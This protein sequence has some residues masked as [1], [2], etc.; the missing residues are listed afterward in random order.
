MKRALLWLA[1]AF[2]VGSLLLAGT[3]A[4]GKYSNGFTIDPTI[5]GDW[6]TVI[7]PNPD[8]PPATVTCGPFP[9]KKRKDNGNVLSA[10]EFKLPPDWP[11]QNTYKISRWKGGTL[12]QK[13]P[14][15]HPGGTVRWV[16][17]PKAEDA[18]PGG[19]G[20]GGSV[21]I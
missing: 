19:V 9:C 16:E 21:T 1:A 18:A 11:D 4:A 7:L 3:G 14:A 20:P 10:D 17:V 6:F 12:L 2:A 8:P 13:V 15:P 5:A